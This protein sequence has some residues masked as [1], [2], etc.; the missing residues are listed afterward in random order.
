MR[1][2]PATNVRYS[3]RVGR[4]SAVSA[5]CVAAQITPFGHG[6]GGRAGN[7]VATH[8]GGSVRVLPDVPDHSG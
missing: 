6:T 8:I 3:A 5:M 2:L 1:S 4:R 7:Q